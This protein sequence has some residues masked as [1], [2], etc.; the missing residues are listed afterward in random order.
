[1]EY[2][3]RSDLKVGT[4]FPDF[5]LPDQSKKS[6]RLSDMLGGFPG[7]ITFIRGHF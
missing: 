6:R 5:E 4:L 3:M 7:V 2:P 1:M